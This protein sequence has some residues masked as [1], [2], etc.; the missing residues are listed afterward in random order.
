MFD[1]L[2]FLA[3]LNI[4]YYVILYIDNIKVLP[5][6]SLEEKKAHLEKL[7]S[8]DDL[9]NKFLVCLMW[10]FEFRYTLLRHQYEGV[11]SVAGVDVKALQN[12][13]SES[14]SLDDDDDEREK[15]KEKEKKTPS[16]A[17]DALFCISTDKGTKARHQFI[18]NHVKFKKTRGLLLADDMGLGKTIQGIGGALLRLKIVSIQREAEGITAV[19]KK[20]KPTIIVCPNHE[21]L[22]QWHISLIISG[23]D[24][25]S[26]FK[27]QKNMALKFSG[28]IY[29]LLTRYNLQTEVKAFATER[30]SKLFP[31]LDYDFYEMMENQYLASK[32]KAKN[33]YR[34][35]YE[36]ISQTIMRLLAIESDES[37]RQDFGMVLIDE[38]HFLRNLE[39]FWG[40]GSA[41]L[42]RFCE[43]VVLLSG[44][45]Y[46]NSNQDMA[47]QMTIIDAKHPSSDIYWWEKATLECNLDN[48]KIKDNIKEWRKNFMLRRDK[49]LL[50]DTLPAKKVAKTQ[51]QAPLNELYIYACYEVHFLDAVRSKLADILYYLQA[52][53][54]LYLKTHSSS[55]M[56]KFTH[57]IQK[58]F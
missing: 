15:E 24:P 29:I 7:N 16:P 40:F 45:P 55:F 48:D 56:I 44:T 31:A 3:H 27:Y 5:I 57:R 10:D 28:N 11:F 1:A 58:L 51:V 37:F 13:I 26:I 38:S 39:A 22:N 14:L 23:V 17:H 50:K 19:Y 21:V 8:D 6:L 35:K 25:D 47:S 30:R 2:F 4:S 52:I 46:N 12:S 18:I 41:M 20:E 33:E 32:G 49:T 36:T 53:F 54:L 9:A 42:G 34:E 43:R